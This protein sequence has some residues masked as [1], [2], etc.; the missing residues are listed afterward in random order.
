M[1]TARSNV[2][3]LSPRKYLFKTATKLIL[4]N[5]PLMTLNEVKFLNGTMKTQYYF[6]VMGST[7]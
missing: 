1:S 5:D 7:T 4:S 2:S 3:F 6:S